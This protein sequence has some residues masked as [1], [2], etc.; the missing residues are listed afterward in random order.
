M[1]SKRRESRFEVS[2][3]SVGASVEQSLQSSL[4]AHSFPPIRVP[5]CLSNGFIFIQRTFRR[6]NGTARAA[7][8]ATT[9][10][11]VVIMPSSSWPPPGCNG[12]HV[13]FS[14]A[15]DD[16]STGSALESTRALR[17]YSSRLVPPSASCGP[18]SS[19]WISSFGRSFV[20]GC[21]CSL[22]GDAV[23]RDCC[24]PTIR[25]R[26]IFYFYPAAI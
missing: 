9:A 5:A 6:R 4:S 3:C 2:S 13:F 11:P 17:S 18:A 19:E 14:V 23:R 21:S 25:R 26:A 12:L 15:D 7:I 24:P 8:E 10:A 20:F 16:A 22:R 1:Y